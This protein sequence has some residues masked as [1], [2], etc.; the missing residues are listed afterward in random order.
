MRSL[1]VRFIYAIFQLTIPRFEA[2][3]FGDITGS[4]DKYALRQA[5]TPKAQV[6]HCVSL[7]VPQ[8][9]RYT[10]QVD[11]IG[12]ETVERKPAHFA[13]RGEAG[14]FVCNEPFLYALVY[15][16]YLTFIGKYT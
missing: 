1:C 14:H 11:V 2:N 15:E 13:Q 10:L 4:I 16:S 6:V 9:V 5:K 8:N 3:F 7:K 12:T